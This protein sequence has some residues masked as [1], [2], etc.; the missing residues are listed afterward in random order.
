MEKNIEETS[1][2]IKETQIKS[3]QI[4]DKDK[5]DV[6]QN[7]IDINEKATKKILQQCKFKKYNYLKHNSKLAAKAT[8]FQRRQ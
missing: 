7:T 6:I 4:L 2:I 1:K 3:K 5:Y 8:D